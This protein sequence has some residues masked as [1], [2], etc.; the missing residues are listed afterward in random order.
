MA[1]SNA[2]GTNSSF[3]S[4]DQYHNMRREVPRVDPDQV[5]RLRVGL[6]L[7]KEQ[8]S[9]LY[10]RQRFNTRFGLTGSIG[11]ALHSWRWSV[12]FCAAANLSL[13]STWAA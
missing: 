11:S 3:L 9:H 10:W 7:I 12:R 1:V 6:G 2:G 5:C 13:Y 4:V 8:N